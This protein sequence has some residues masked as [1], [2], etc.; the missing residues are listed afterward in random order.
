MIS[1]LRAFVQRHHTG[2]AEAEIMLQPQP[3]AVD[4]GRR[5]GATQLPGQFV[6]LRQSVAPSGCP[7]DNSPP[8]GLVTILP[9]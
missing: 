1:L 2:A 8:E 9:P 7:F 6:A 5:R 3:R 4:L